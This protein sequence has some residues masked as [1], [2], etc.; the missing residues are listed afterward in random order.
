MEDVKITMITIIITVQN[1]PTVP[2]AQELQ[3]M[4]LSRMHLLVPFSSHIIFYSNCVNQFY[5]YC[6]I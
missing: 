3:S 4:H 6:S 1:N 2:M 5:A